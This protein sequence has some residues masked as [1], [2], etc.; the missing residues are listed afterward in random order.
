MFSVRGRTADE[1]WRAVVTAV[2]D[3]PSQASRGGPTREL[4]HVALE[5]ENPEQRWVLSRE[6]AVNPAFAIAE[7]L[8]I[9]AGR[10][11][12]EFLNY[13]NP[14]YSRFAG[15]GPEYHGAYGH[16][17]RHAFGLDQIERAYRTFDS[18]PDT[19][20][21]VLQIWHPEL[22]FPG[23]DGQPAAEDIPCNVC[24]ILKV[25]DG[26]LHWVQVMRSND[27]FRG[28][29]HN[30]VQFT[31]LQAVLAGWLGLKVGPYHHWSDSLHAYDAD[32]A[33]Y[34]VLSDPPSADTRDRLSLNRPD[35]QSTFPRVVAI[36]D[37]FVS[38]D[39]TR[40]EV[41]HAIAG[42]R[43]LEP[44]QPYISL[45]AADTSRRRGWIDLMA[46]SLNSC[47]DQAL[48]N[49]GERWVSSAHYRVHVT[50][51]ARSSPRETLGSP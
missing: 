2:R 46:A 21:V 5:I 29:P 35:W 34:S 48:R 38:G 3:A 23:E 27:V 14:L 28:L 13:W 16:R 50:P 1:A 31:S 32:A 9:L 6:P 39:L 45:L 33:I 18:N 8:W 22:D 26:T 49:L 47:P 30:F 15:A 12:A 41:E 43:G 37:R 40:A 24:G 7:V 11:D 19:R 44:W 17:L 51:S 20:Q 42:A 36:A 4:L 10:R 25:R